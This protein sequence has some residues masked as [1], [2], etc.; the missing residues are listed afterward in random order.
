MTLFQ[1]SVNAQDP[2]DTQGK[3]NNNAK[4]PPDVSR[5]RKAAFAN[6]NTGGKHEKSAEVVGMKQS[7]CTCTRL[8]VIMEQEK[9]EEKKRKERRPLRLAALEQNRSEQNRTRPQKTPINRNTS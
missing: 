3:T 2:K 5:E 9:R 8:L 4:E 6:Y 1:L 7:Y